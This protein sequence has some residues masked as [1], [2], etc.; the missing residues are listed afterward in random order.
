MTH[1]TDT[2][3]VLPQKLE[4]ICLA[5]AEESWNK[6]EK[7]WKLIHYRRKEKPSDI[8]KGAKICRGA[9]PRGG[10]AQATVSLAAIRLAKS[11]KEGSANGITA[12]NCPR[13]SVHFLPVLAREKTEKCVLR[14]SVFPSVGPGKK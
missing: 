4:Q 10:T 12:D 11:R 1:K 9:S 2:K 7:R 6:V 8:H 14:F 13:P 5:T 3:I